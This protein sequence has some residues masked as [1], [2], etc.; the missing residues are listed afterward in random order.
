MIRLEGVTKR[1][2]RRGAVVALNSVTLSIPGGG[3]TLL[4]GANGAG[5]S[6]LL[7]VIAGT[8]APTSGRV[9]RTGEVG[10][11]LGN[12]FGLY[13]RLSAREYLRYIG[14][15]RGLS[16]PVLDARIGT[17]L[18]EL[19]I[20]GFAHR[21]CGEFSAGMKQRTALAASIIHEP[22]ILLLDEPTTGLDLSAR[23]HVMETI[24]RLAE[25]GRG[26]IVSTH[27]PEEVR[28]LARRVVVLN[29][30][31]VII[32]VAADDPLFDAPGGIAAVALTAI[33]EADVSAPSRRGS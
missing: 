12:S 10:I 2:G 17:V 26:M 31:R 21:R 16:G 19:E 3:V 28:P 13:D 6:T 24:R 9:H 11:L 5:K 8:I 22:E 1:F 27:H 20:A 18:R 7:R 33:R 25:T 23:G 4:L 32:D 14:A 15:L 29:A 30:G